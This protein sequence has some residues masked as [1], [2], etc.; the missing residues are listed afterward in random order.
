M[1]RFCKNCGAV[2]PPDT[3][4]CVACGTKVGEG[5]PKR[6]KDSKEADAAKAAKTADGAEKTDEAID[7][8][9]FAALKDKQAKIQTDSHAEI[10]TEKQPVIQGDKQPGPLKYIAASLRRGMSSLAAYFKSPRKMIPI[11][12]LAAV[13]LVLS[14]LP[15]MGINPL[16]VQVLSFIT[17]A[18]G[19]M[20]GGF[21]GALGGI[22]GKAVFAYFF[23]ALLIPLVTGKA[24]GKGFAKGIK[25]FFAG[26]YIQG[27]GV[28]A[29]L[30]AGIGLALIIFNFLSGN[31][32]LVNSMPGI[33]GLILAIR[34][35]FRKSGFLRGLIL[36]FANKR[37]KGRIPANTTINHLAA[38]Y[39]AGSL[40]GVA[41]S[42][43]SV[44]FL[45][46]LAGVILII[47]SIIIRIA[48]RTR[49]EAIPA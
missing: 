20:Y 18:Q 6:V 37:S 19:G 23:S 38:G 15:A 33:V 9:G 1:S 28:L 7:Q 47:A 17:F 27:L 5:A 29:P 11:L 14:I 13:W 30:L 22:L 44:P 43:L 35:G 40:A 8:S 49:K 32:S 48:A 2:L 41:L 10:Q 24:S 34:T 45:P 42:A 36:S 31:A 12:I 39:A 46:Y 16:P 3:L 25:Q 4:F 26:F 21:W